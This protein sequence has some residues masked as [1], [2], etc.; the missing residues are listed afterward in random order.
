MLLRDV[1]GQHKRLF[2]K[3]KMQECISRIKE[4]STE[5]Q[6]EYIKNLKAENILFNKVV[7]VKT[8]QEIKEVFVLEEAYHLIEPYIKESVYELHYRIDQ[9]L[10]YN[11]RILQVISAESNSHNANRSFSARYPQMSQIAANKNARTS[12]SVTSAAP[13]KGKFSSKEEL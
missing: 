6:E 10:E 2:E 11:K 1:G 12:A 5:Q 13:T 7:S 3:N 9:S 8:V 4:L